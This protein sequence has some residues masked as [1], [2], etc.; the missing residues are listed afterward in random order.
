M[1]TPP[2]YVLLLK[3]ERPAWPV[4]K[5]MFPNHQGWSGL[6]LSPCVQNT[7]ARQ[8]QAPAGLSKEVLMIDVVC[9]RQSPHG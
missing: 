1:A 2:L 4:R 3:S 8:A 6:I 5:G 9:S 7:K